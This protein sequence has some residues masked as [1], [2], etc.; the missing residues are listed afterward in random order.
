MILVDWQIEELCKQYQMVDPFD[1]SLINPA[2]LDIR[3]GLTAEIEAEEGF[4]P[5]DLS[6]T[7]EDNPFWLYPNECILVG[8]LETLKIPDHIC[9]K[10]FLKSSR[11]RELYEHLEAGWIDSGFGGILTM[12]IKNVSRFMRLPLYLGFKI[13]Q[14]VFFKLDAIPKHTYP[15]KG[16][17]HNDLKVQKSK[18]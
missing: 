14:L 8:S 4:K 5:V 13:G 6:S 2:S 1:A 3:I 18:G 17:Y 12:E 7:T 16:R 11:G 9:S 15:E 10:I